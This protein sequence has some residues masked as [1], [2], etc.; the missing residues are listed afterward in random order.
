MIE[1]IEGYQMT[2]APKF[3]VKSG[4]HKKMKFAKKTLTTL[5]FYDIVIRRD[6][7]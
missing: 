7:I 5:L 4:N 2:D 1:S 6:E 3:A